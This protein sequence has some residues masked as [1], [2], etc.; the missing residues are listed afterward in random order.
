M[1]TI[2]HPSGFYFF[3]RGWLSSNN[4]LLVDDEK[5]ILIDTGYVTH[6]DQTLALVQSHLAGRP[7]VKIINTHLHSDHCGG[8]ARLQSVYPGSQICIPPGH[9][10]AV[11]HWDDDVLTFKATGQQCLRFVPHHVLQPGGTFESG[12]F[13]WEVHAAPGHDTHSV[14]L[15]EPQQG[16]LISADAL[17]SNGFGVVFPELEGL[18]AF[19]EVSSTLDLIQ[20]LDAKVVYPGHGS[21]FT[22]VGAAIDRARRRLD[23]F[24]S[25]PE[26]HQTYGVKVLLKFK[27]ME[28][29]SLPLNDFLAWAVQTPYLQLMHQQRELDISSWV[30]S[31]VHQL[32][33]ND[34]ARLDGAVLSNL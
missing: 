32:I 1:Q 19:A 23:Q 11:L 15:F 20:S 7:L 34:A 17:W 33:T 14:I 25:H 9:F 10:D 16:L 29:Q 27:L 8:N 22:D 28:F 12:S 2:P 5:A 31:F 6:A 26:K 24:I 18:D 4:I 21:S 13:T 3:E 30:L